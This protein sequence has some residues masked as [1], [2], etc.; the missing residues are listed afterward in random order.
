MMP[1]RYHGQMRPSL[2]SVPLLCASV[3]LA[4][5]SVAGKQDAPAITSSPEPTVRAPANDDSSPVAEAQKVL[6]LQPM[7]RSLEPQAITL[8]EKALT[9][10]YS[11][12]VQVGSPR[13][14]PKAAFYRPRKRYRAEKLLTYLSNVAPQ[15]AYRVLG[16]TGVDISTTK[17]RVR[18]WGI[19]GLASIDGRVSVMSMFRCVRG[20]S[21]RQHGRERL[22]KTAVHEVGHTLGLLHCPTRGC[23][24]EDARGKNTTS[25]REHLLCPT[26]RRLLT[27]SG[28]VLPPN[29]NP[30]WPEP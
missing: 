1:V 10:F 11:F 28:Y 19:M 24:M 5:C 17:G 27:R 4:A 13:P 30:P 7:G 6:Y 3:A 29:P 8:V 22:G 15:D 12:E 21:S 26:C 20:A 2:P 14:L 18:D 23:L 16:L 25:D 9:E